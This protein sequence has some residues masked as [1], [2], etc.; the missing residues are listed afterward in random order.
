MAKSFE[1]IEAKKK[2]NNNKDN[3]LGRKMQFGII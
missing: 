3:E 2:N 1:R